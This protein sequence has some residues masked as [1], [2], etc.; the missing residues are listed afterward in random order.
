MESQNAAM[1]SIALAVVVLCCS[2]SS[3][4]GYYAWMYSK[5]ATLK[6]T[7][8]ENCDFS[9][10]SKELGK[11]KYNAD[12]IGGHD[13]I[14]SVKVPSGLKVTLYEHDGFTGDTLVLTGD[15]KCLSNFNDMT[16]SIEIS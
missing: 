14:S 4:G 6:A 3:I 16:S 10:A 13:R 11:G 8:Y 15:N 9:G 7:F 12:K 5:G 2:F 1:V